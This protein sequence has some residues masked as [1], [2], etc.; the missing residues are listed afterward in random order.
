MT[1]AIEAVAGPPRRVGRWRWTSWAPFPD[2]L[3]KVRALGGTARRSNL[4]GDGRDAP[5]RPDGSDRAVARVS[6]WLPATSDTADAVIYRYPP[7]VEGEE[8]P[9][10]TDGSTGRIRWRPSVGAPRSR[11]W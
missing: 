11:P 6:S 2:A 1:K 7:L 10:R 3:V 4:D 8:V 9:M 5:T